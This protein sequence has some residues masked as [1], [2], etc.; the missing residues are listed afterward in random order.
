MVN[1]SRSPDV[2]RELLNVKQNEILNYSV[3]NRKKNI[4]INY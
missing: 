4:Q 3:E 2:D 1:N